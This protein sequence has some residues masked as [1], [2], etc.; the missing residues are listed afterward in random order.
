MWQY[1]DYILPPCSISNISPIEQATPPGRTFLDG[2]G[3]TPVS[4]SLTESLTINRRRGVYYHR[5]PVWK[6]EPGGDGPSLSRDG[7]SERHVASGDAGTGSPCSENN[8]EKGLEQ[9][10]NPTIADLVLPLHT[11]NPVTLSEQLDQPTHVLHPQ[12]SFSVGITLSQPGMQQGLEPKGLSEHD[13]LDTPD[14]SGSCQAQS[15]VK[16]P[17]KLS[18]DIP[19]SQP[20]QSKQPEKSSTS[21]NISIQPRKAMDLWRKEDSA[22]SLLLGIPKREFRESTHA[23]Q[24]NVPPMVQ[25]ELRWDTDHPDG[26]RYLECYRDIRSSSSSGNGFAIRSGSRVIC[27]GDTAPCDEDEQ[28]H[29]SFDIEFGEVYLVLRLYSD[30]WASC[31]KIDAEKPVHPTSPSHGHVPRYSRTTWPTSYD[32]IKFLPLCC[33]TIEA[34]F[35]RYLRYHPVHGNSKLPITDPTKGQ[36]VIPPKR[37]DSLAAGDN[38]SHDA[39]GILI[40]LEYFS[41]LNFPTMERDKVYKVANTMENEDPVGHVR[42]CKPDYYESG[43]SGFAP[44]LSRMQRLRNRLLRHVDGTGKPEAKVSPAERRPHVSKSK[45]GPVKQML[46][47]VG[48][49]KSLQTQ[50][51]T[52]SSG[53]ASVPRQG[54]SGLSTAGSET[55]RTSNLPF[56]RRLHGSTSTGFGSVLGTRSITRSRSPRR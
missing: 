45:I 33:V 3:G 21:S 30:L 50:E 28:R 18:S 19:E 2:D 25:E 16:L 36:I 41:Q 31:I 47:S 8:S 52:Q 46:S 37:N 29:D 1:Q 40:P 14:V 7:N 11:S 56:G 53:L 4:D 38:L 9:L 44:K 26:E 17:V 27:V 54:L 6:L 5:P 23:I 42:E 12:Q 22:D 43:L 32:A 15:K 49:S 34:N 55:A 48:T 10:S 20:S 13:A 24:E 51:N 35:A 39:G